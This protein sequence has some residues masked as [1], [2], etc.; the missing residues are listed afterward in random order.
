MTDHRNTTPT[1]KDRPFADNSSDAV[2]PPAASDDT[3]ITVDGITEIKKNKKKKKSRPGKTRRAITGFEGNKINRLKPC[4]AEHNLTMIEFYA[5]APTT[6]AEYAE[7]KR[8]YAADRSFPSRIEEAI[9]R[10]RQKRRFDSQRAFLFDKYLALA[11]ID[12]SPRMFQGLDPLE[13]KE[14]TSD[15]IRTLTARDVVHR[16]LPGS[17]FYS[18]NE[19]RGWTVNFPIVVKGF[20]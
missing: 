13:T 10:Y 17:K 18:A 7:E 16:G 6:P 11:G 15:E 19:P 4:C 12:S 1:S 14:M 3:P 5:D 8:L 20:L 9:Q 2:D